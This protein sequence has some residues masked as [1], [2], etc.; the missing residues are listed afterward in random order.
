MEIASLIKKTK[1]FEDF[2]RLE[3]AGRFSHAYLIFSPD[4]VQNA[5]FCKLMAK[6]LECPSM[7]GVCGD[8]VKIEAGIHPDVLNFPKGKSFLVS[9]ATDIIEQINVLPMLASYKIFVINNFNTATTQAQNKLLKSLEEPPRNVI[10]LLNATDLNPILQTIISRVQKIDLK[11]LAKKDIESYLLEKDGAI[12]QNAIVEGNGWIGQTLKF[13]EDEN[14]KKDCA[15]VENMM[16]TMKKSADVIKFSPSFASKENFA[17][18][19]NILENYFEKEL[20]RI[21]S[22]EQSEFT[23]E[24]VAEIFERINM[25]KKQFA[26]NCNLNLISDTLLM[27]ILEVKYLCG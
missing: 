4:E 16:L 3:D 22:G 5:A 9:D 25:A 20:N 11:P 6:K 26:S 12:D 2:C 27:G 15:F 21:I 19:L 7:C 10:F 24:A 8:C 18:R 17:L 14:F 1:E 23:K 13:N